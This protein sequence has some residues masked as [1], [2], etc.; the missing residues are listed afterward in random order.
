MANETDG[1]DNTSSNTNSTDGSDQERITPSPRPSN[2][3]N[4]TLTPSGEDRQRETETS[5]DDEEYYVIVKGREAED[6]GI[7]GTWAETAPKVTIGVSAPVHKKVKGR[8]EA[9]QFL[10]QG[11]VTPEDTETHMQDIDEIKRNRSNRQLRTRPKTRID[12]RG[13]NGEKGSRPKE[14]IDKPQVSQEDQTKEPRDKPPREKPKQID[15]EDQIRRIEEARQ[16][17]TSIENELRTTKQALEESRSE[18]DGHVETIKTLTDE[19]IETKAQLRE[20]QKQMGEL[21]RRNNE[22]KSA[23]ETERKRSTAQT[24]RNHQKPSSQTPTGK[25]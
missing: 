23:L 12:Y 20:A 7:Y 6:T 5:D 8:K 18:V 1:D 10:R 13:L 25:Q 11:G 2:T 16:Q 19:N 24:I 21:Q 15:Y 17:T 22:L 9:K 4:G 14:N 3:N